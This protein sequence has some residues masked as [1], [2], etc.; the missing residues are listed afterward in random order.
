MPSTTSSDSRHRARAAVVGLVLALGFA[1]APARSH[2]GS[3]HALLRQAAGA[4]HRHEF[5]AALSTLAKLLA[6]EPRNDQAWLMRAA[7]LQ[8]Q[9]DYAASRTA[10]RTL[11]IQVTPVVRAACLAA[12]T[13][14]GAEGKRATL[15]LESALRSQ[16]DDPAAV[17]GWALGILAER[18]TL[19]RD[20]GMA[21]GA[22]R[23]G[24][25]T[26]PGDVYLTAALAD[27]LLDHGR[28]ADALALLP[29]GEIPLELLLRRARARVALGAGQAERAEL[30]ERLERTSRAE[31]HTHARSEAYFFLH[32]ERDPLAALPL[33][34]ANFRDQREPIDRALLLAAASAA[35]RHDAA[36]P[37]HAWLTANELR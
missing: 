20:Y 6:R 30:A 9:G 33:A 8:V 16:G 1:A 23:Q 18:R 27:L 13:G 2:E 4:Q 35:G 34:I 25:E 31:G 36:Q 22:L 10:C 37:V 32:V 12:A 19:L 26:L 3:S 14:G 29:R 11:S 5:G 15:E 17:R 7:I 21:E 28:A 24:L